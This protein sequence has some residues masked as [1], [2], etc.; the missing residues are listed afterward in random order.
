M[1]FAAKKVAKKFRTSGSVIGYLTYVVVKSGNSGERVN[2]STL[3]NTYGFVA[4]NAVS[5]SEVYA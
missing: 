1:P 3:F 5:F 2:G 4:V